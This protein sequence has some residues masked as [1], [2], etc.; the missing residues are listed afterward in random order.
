VRQ[1]VDEEILPFAFE[2]ETAGKVP[3]AVR[4]PNP[5]LTYSF[6][7]GDRHSKDM[8]SLDT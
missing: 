4:G 2:W 6:N 8:L 3:D 7:D 5:I 1:Y